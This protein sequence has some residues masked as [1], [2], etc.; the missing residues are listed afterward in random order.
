MFIFLLYTGYRPEDAFGVNKISLTEALIK[1][2]P[3]EPEHKKT[4]VYRR[5]IF[6]ERTKKALL[7]WV[8]LLPKHA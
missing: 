2:T 3:Y 4:E 8:N 7:E 6:N 1:G 5:V